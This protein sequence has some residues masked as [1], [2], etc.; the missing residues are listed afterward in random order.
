MLQDARHV[1]ISQEAQLMQHGF[2]MQV[3][4]AVPA[5]IGASRFSML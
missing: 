1:P 5:W 4:I 2:L 3:L